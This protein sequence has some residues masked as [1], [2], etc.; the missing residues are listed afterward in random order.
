MKNRNKKIFALLGL[1]LMLVCSSFVTVFGAEEQDYVT[2]SFDVKINALVNNTY[3]VTENITVDF[4]KPHHGIYRYINEENMHITDVHAEGQPYDT[5]YKDENLIIK[6]GSENEMV[7]GVQT[8]TIKYNMQVVT[9]KNQPTNFMNLN[10]FPH[11]WDTPVEKATCEITMPKVADYANLSV[12]SGKIGDNTNSANVQ[13]SAPQGGTTITLSAQ[14]IKADEGA[15]VYLP[16]PE[17]YWENEKTSDWAIY[18]IIG[19]LILVPLLIFLIWLFVGKNPKVVQ[20]V[21]FYPPEGMT[22]GEVGYI[23]D[24]VVDKKD[25]VSMI[26]YYADKGYLTLREYGNKKFEVTKVKDI[27]PEEKKFSRTLFNGLFAKGDKVKLDTLDEKF[28]QAYLNAK[29]FLT[30]ERQIYSTAS[31]VGRG[32]AVFLMGLM[33]LVCSAFSFVY[34]QYTVFGI[35]AGL[36]PAMLAS[37]GA[38]LLVSTYDRRLG[39]FGFANTGKMIVGGLLLILGV[40]VTITILLTH[41]ISNYLAVA[42]GVAVLIC[43][44]FIFRM[45]ARTKESAND[46]GKILGLKQF[47]KMAEKDKLEALIEENPMYFYNI[48]PYAYVLGLSDKW[49]KDFEDIELKAPFWYE[50]SIDTNFVFNVFLFSRIMNGCHHSFSNNIH[51]PADTKIGGIG[52]GNFSGGGFGGGGGG[53]W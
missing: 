11:N 48:I 45:I 22:P 12:T 23:I 9:N 20:T 37:I 50:N 2:K 40:G 29:D 51:I 32:V 19:I 41:S 6:V 47:I 25:L 10:V 16:L 35:W 18:P 49:I 43:L 53:A 17:G 31:R 15:T 14:N 13:Y 39:A 30:N 27:D 46:L 3:E 7:S 4:N 8:Y 28:G 26:V 38:F 21:E 24:G 52:G 33:L 1:V 42:V 5:E 36:I 44:F 34:E